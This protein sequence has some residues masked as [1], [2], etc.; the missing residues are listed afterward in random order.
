VYLP[1]APG[2]VGSGSVSTL[3]LRGVGRTIDVQV[4]RLDAFGVMSE[5]RGL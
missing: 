1:D 4:R 5:A 2:L 3:T